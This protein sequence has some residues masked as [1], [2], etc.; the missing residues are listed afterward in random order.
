MEAERAPAVARA[1]K[2]LPHPTPCQF[3]G[4]NNIV[5][6]DREC[7][8]HGRMQFYGSDSLLVVRG[9]QNLLGLDANLGSGDAIVIGENTFAWRVRVWA[10][11]GTTCV[12]GDNCLLSEDVNIRTTDH[13]SIVDL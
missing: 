2:P 3:R 7:G 9:G 11:G 5:V 8:V 12:I 13:H 1:A 4:S 6:I 10:Q